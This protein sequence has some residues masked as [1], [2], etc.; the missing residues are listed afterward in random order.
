MDISQLSKAT[1]AVCLAEQHLHAILP[2]HPDG[3]LTE[4]TSAVAY[5]EQYIMTPSNA[6]LPFFVLFGQCEDPYFDENNVPFFPS[7]VGGLFMSAGVSDFWGL[8]YFGG[9]ITWYHKNDEGLFIPF[10]SEIFH[11]TLLEEI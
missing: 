8:V 3:I 9:I 10:C 6:A 2:F 7:V 1:L 11:S 4:F 5:Q